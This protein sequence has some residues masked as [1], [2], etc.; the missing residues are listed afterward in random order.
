[1]ELVATEDVLVDAETSSD[2]SPPRESPTPPR[3]RLIPLEDVEVALTLALVEVEDT[4]LLRLVDDEETTDEEETTDDEDDADSEEDAIVAVEAAELTETE[5]L[6]DCDDVVELEV[7]A[8]APTETVR[9]SALRSSPSANAEVELTADE[10]VEEEDEADCDG[11]LE[12]ILEAADGIEEEAAVLELTLDEVGVEDV[13][14]ALV[15]AVDEAAAPRVMSRPRRLTASPSDELVVVAAELAWAV[16]NEA[17][18]V[19][20]SMLKDTATATEA[21]AETSSGSEDAAVVVVSTDEED[22]PAVAVCPA[23]DEDEGEELA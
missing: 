4:V 19:A 10:T 17:T 12:T 20:I 16:V 6:L 15:R 7:V 2:V 14:T 11:M 3:L 22:A 9:P 8:A 1:M 5:T 23:L 18:S 21:D 13:T